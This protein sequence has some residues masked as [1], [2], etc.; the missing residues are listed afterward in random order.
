MKMPQYAKLLLDKN[1]IYPI[2]NYHFRTR[3]VTLKEKEKVYN[4]VDIQNVEFDFSGF[5]EIEKKSFLFL[6]E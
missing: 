5:T 3:Q 4:T 1:V 6:F 2:V